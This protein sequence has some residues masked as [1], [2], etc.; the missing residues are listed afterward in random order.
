MREG[1]PRKVKISGS[2]F[3]VSLQD[4]AMFLI[5]VLI[6]HAGLLCLSLSNAATPWYLDRDVVILPS[7]EREDRGRMNRQVPDPVTFPKALAVCSS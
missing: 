2:G 5:L 3:W 1:K 7:G 6:L 4:L